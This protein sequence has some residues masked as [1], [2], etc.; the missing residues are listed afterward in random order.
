[1]NSSSSRPQL[2]TFQ[3][4]PPRLSP[5]RANTAG[6]GK[7]STTKKGKQSTTKKGAKKRSSSLPDPHSHS[8]TKWFKP[9][10]SQQ[11]C[12][13]QQLNGGSQTADGQTTGHPLPL[14]STYS[15]S[16]SS[17]VFSG[18]SEEVASAPLSQPGE[19]MY[20]GVVCKEVYF[21]VSCDIIMTV[22]ATVN[23]VYSQAQE[24]GAG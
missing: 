2:H 4:Q 23:T 16:S 14:H 11:N 10:H 18:G 15:S 7:Q 20:T 6:T 5:E 22:T 1:M 13:S 19:C 8:L 12:D 21:N 9:C 24:G 17:G 3:S